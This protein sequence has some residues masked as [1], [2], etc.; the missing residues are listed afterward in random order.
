MPVSKQILDGIKSSEVVVAI[1]GERHLWDWSGHKQ[2]GVVDEGEELWLFS[3]H[4]ALREDCRYSVAE[5]ERR[6]EQGGKRPLPA[7]HTIDGV[8]EGAVAVRGSSRA[9]AM[10]LAHKLR[11]TLFFGLSQGGMV[12]VFTGREGE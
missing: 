9:A 2:G 1:D 6:L 4:G 3:R 11:L 8:D 5:V 7:T 10:K 12:A